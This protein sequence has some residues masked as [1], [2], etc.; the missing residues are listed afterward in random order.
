LSAVIEIRGLHKT[1]RSLRR[2]RRV[3]LDG[4]DMTVH[5]GQVH[6]F[7]GPNGSGKSTTLRVILGLARAGAG[8]VRVFGEPVPRASPRLARRIGALV[9]S[10]RFFPNFT[11]WDTLALL[12][13]VGR[14]PRSRV[15]EVLELVG[16][17]ERGHDRVSTYSL[18][19]RQRLAVA[20]AVLKHPDL[21]ILD[22]PANGLDPAGIRQ[23][24]DL[25]RALADS[26]M[27]VVLASHILA[28]VQQLCDS[29]TFIA[30]GRRV[31]AGS[32]ADVL[33]QHATG[34]WRVRLEST[35]DLPTAAATLAAAGLRVASLPDH[36]V[37]S[38]L[39]RAADVTRALV[40]QQLFVAELTPEPIALEDVFL[41]L[42]EA[43]PTGRH[44]LS[45]VSA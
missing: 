27:T 40:T 20:M 31:G 37:V 28:E 39:H 11:G 44:R 8:E 22:E 10:P 14:V 16:L 15:D 29:V 18:G 17:R 9:E 19:M 7:L 32:V 24:R 41:R 26:G 13:D 33:S 34:R 5:T 3:A 25:M 30:G 35:D 6:G 38:G 43:S 4:L 23:M 1:Y 42:T 36:L 21:L 2:G 12:C 45:E